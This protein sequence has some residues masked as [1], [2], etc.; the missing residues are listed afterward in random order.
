MVISAPVGSD[1]NCTEARASG[2]ALGLA[3]TTAL[4]PA[5][6]ASGDGAGTGLGAELV[7]ALGVV[8]GALLGTT[9]VAEGPPHVAGVQ[10][11]GETLDKSAVLSV[12]TIVSAAA[13]PV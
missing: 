8:L 3:G 2:T 4:G 6:A 10:A 12:S 11:A 13:N 7:G 1:D 5:G 9:M